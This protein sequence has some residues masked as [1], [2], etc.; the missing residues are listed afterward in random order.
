[1]IS[2]II[3]ALVCFFSSTLKV[4]VNPL[5]CY[6]FI[7]RSNFDNLQD[8][9][10]DRLHAV[11]RGGSGGYGLARYG[12]IGGDG[13]NVII[14]ASKTATLENIK[15]SYPQQRFKAADGKPCK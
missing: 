1:M 14:K 4:V 12:G 3:R 5:I 15:A 7:T 13:G 8:F 11:M 9:F 10:M 2:S 6:T